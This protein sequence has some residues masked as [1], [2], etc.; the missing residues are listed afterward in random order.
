MALMARTALT[1]SDATA[2]GTVL[3]GNGA[4]AGQ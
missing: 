3:N 2:D 1:D 4:P